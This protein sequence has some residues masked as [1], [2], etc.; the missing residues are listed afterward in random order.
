LPWTV[1]F[2]EG[3]WE[4]QQIGQTEDLVGDELFLSGHAFYRDTD[5]TNDRQ[6]YRVGFNTSP[7]R[8]V[9]LNA[10]YRALRDDS[11]YHNHKVAVESAGY[12]AF[13]NART[14]DTDAFQTKLALRLASWLKLTLT[15][16]L[17][18]TEYHTATAPEPISGSPGGNILAGN[19]DAHVY[20]ISA[21]VTPLARLNF[22]GTFTRSDSR[23]STAQNG[24]PSIVPYEGDIY[25]VSADV[26]YALTK[27][28]ALHAT[29]AFSRGNFGQDN[30]AFGLPLGLDY[31]RHGLM[32]GLTHKLNEHLTTTLRYAFYKYSE[33]STG[34]F[35]D[36]TANGVFG[37]LVM[38]W[39]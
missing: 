31:T 18:A 27:A 35:N 24:D 1:L 14:I 22:L 8:W 25:S 7:W 38:K 3:R 15:Y 13:I 34:G 17:V 21:S 20:G 32:V 12:S 16:Q 29:Y 2:A 6:Q 37:T 5:F 33:P 28:T 10:E 4:Q 19:Y 39:P 30:A 11:D 36:Y 9:S 26:N 23:T